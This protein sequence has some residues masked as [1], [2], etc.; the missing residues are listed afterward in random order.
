[1][2]S[3]QIEIQK[4]ID[5]FKARVEFLD[6]WIVDLKKKKDFES[7]DKA[8][9]LKTERHHKAFIIRMRENDQKMFKTQQEAAIKE[10]RAQF[11]PLIKRLR[12]SIMPDVKTSKLAE[13]L[14]KRFGSKRSI[15]EEVKDF[16]NASEL[17]A[18]LDSEK[19][20]KK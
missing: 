8:Y 7:L 18:L 16:Q 9:H 2:N 20:E 12:T 4:Q 1:M 10:M 11:G 19:E 5:G 6:K 13:G 14:G 15:Q 3:E 17:V